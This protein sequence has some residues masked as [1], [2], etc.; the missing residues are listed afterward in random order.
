MLD[1]GDLG[2]NADRLAD[3]VYLLGKGRLFVDLGVRAGVSSEILLMDAEMRGNRVIGVD[4]NECPP[5]LA[6]HPRY[7][8]SQSDS[9]TFL[10]GFELPIDL[11]FFDTLH[12]SEQVLAELY[13]AWPLISVGGWAAFHDT[14]WPVGKHDTYFGVT[15]DRVEVA[16][17]NFFGP[18]VGEACTI[19]SYPESWGMT[20][21]QKLSG[22]ELGRRLPWGDIF[23]ARNM[24]LELAKDFPVERRIIKRVNPPVFPVA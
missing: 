11:C 3:I 5:R 7:A 13:F 23:D 1:R 20:M 12:I 4:V 21:V 16:I 8:F 18:H 24:L 2:P 15:W 14:A 17:D 6:N 9:V 22:R 10:H 19:R